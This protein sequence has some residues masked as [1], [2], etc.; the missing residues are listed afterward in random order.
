MS[1]K[2]ISISTPETGG[3]SGA[4]AVLSGRFS[5]LRRGK[6]YTI[7]RR[8]DVRDR[9]I[10][11]RRVSVRSGMTATHVPR[12]HLRVFRFRPRR[13]EAR[14][15]LGKI[16]AA[17]FRLFVEVNGTRF[18]VISTFAIV[19]YI[20]EKRVYAVVGRPLMYHDVIQG[21]FVFAPETGG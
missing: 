4:R 20:Y 3:L 5:T 2:G 9:L 11:I 13:L 6:W 10:C 12:C 8:F 17:D 7:R 1:S 19:L 16:W 15:G 14:A 18:A 21:Y